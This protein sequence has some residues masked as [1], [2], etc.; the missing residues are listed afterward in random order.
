V[1]VLGQIE[2]ADVATPKGVIT[3]WAV[4]KATGPVALRILRSRPGEFEAGELHATNVHETPDET[5][6]GS[7]NFQIFDAHEP[8]AAGDYIGIT[9]VTGSSIGFL[10]SGSNQLFLVDG[11]LEVGDVDD[12]TSDD[13]EP[14]LSANVEPD[15]DSD[16]YGDETEDGCP[17]NASTHGACPVF[18]P[19]FVPPVVAKVST[20]ATRKVS[21]GSRSTTL[22][23]GRAAIAL[24]NANSVGVKG[25]LKLKLGK[26]VV[27]SKAYSLAAGATGTIKVKLA[28]TALRRIARRGKVKL[29]LGLTAK[30]ATGK[31]FKTTSKLTVKRAKKAR[32]KKRKAKKK[33][34]GG[35][36]PLDGKYVKAPD[37]DENIHFTVT[38]AGRRIVNF[39]GIVTSF[40]YKYKGG[41]L[42]GELGFQFAGIESLSVAANG[43]FSGE[44]KLSDTTTTVTDGKLAGGVATGHVTVKSYGCSG[45]G[46]FRAV[47]TGG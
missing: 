41:E 16:G 33:Q 38:D 21:V 6:I 36:S 22:K 31:T 15:A 11:D 3:S 45:R 39:Q 7:D 1:L 32:K 23:R 27:G 37:S 25:K 40:C 9:L 43:T 14:M 4:R 44:Q 19:P 29:S 12:D 42:V 8:V 24:K 46:T 30:G 20:A 34:G 2:G 5:G 18:T 47:R 13:Y 26:K 10:N 35:G 28:R 17:S